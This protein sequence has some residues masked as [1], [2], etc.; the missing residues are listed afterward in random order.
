[1]RQIVVV[2]AYS[3]FTSMY[4]ADVTVFLERLVKVELATQPRKRKAG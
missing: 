2:D 4:D 1:M 3:S